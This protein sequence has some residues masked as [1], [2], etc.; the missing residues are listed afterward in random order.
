MADSFL[1]RV[2]DAESVVGPTASPES[3]PSTTPC[4]PFLG[5]SEN[6]ALAWPWGS[7]LGAVPRGS[8]AAGHAPS[9]NRTRAAHTALG[10]VFKRK[11][12]GA[13]PSDHLCGNKTCFLS[14]S[15]E[16]TKGLPMSRP[17][18]QPEK[19]LGVS[20]EASR[21]WRWL[22]GRPQERPPLRRLMPFPFC[23]SQLECVS[24]MPTSLA[25]PL[26]CNAPCPPGTCTLTP[27][28]LD[29]SPA[30]A[31]VHCGQRRFW[32]RFQSS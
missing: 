1:P 32:M 30:S 7:Q 13:L 3:T 10:G 19:H 23:S 2:P 16:Q 6:H 20:P 8:S 24:L 4:L 21:V 9:S 27:A 18:H 12:L 5:F 29:G 14:I 28:R 15:E 25:R 31:S 17:Q 26:A 22:A 11:I